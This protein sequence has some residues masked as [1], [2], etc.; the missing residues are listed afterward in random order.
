MSYKKEV[1]KKK[2]LML[3][4]FLKKIAVK[5]LFVFLVVFLILFFCLL[6]FF[7]RDV[8]LG[9]STMSEFRNNYYG[10]P[11][12]ELFQ[13]NET[14]RDKYNSLQEWFSGLCQRLSS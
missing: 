4:A 6:I 13:L 10:I 11:A 8:V 12:Q 3:K 1:L 14:I 7:F 2:I 5:S 9:Q